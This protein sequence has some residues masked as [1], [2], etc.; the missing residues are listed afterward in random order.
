MAFRLVWFCWGLDCG[1]KTTN[2]GLCQPFPDALCGD[3]LDVCV[4]GRAHAYAPQKMAN[5][6]LY[7]A[8]GYDIDN[9]LSVTDFLSIKQKPHIGKYGTLLDGYDSGSY[10]IRTCDQWIK[11]NLVC[12]GNVPSCKDIKGVI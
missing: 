7:F 11:R 3:A 6:P 1:K 9:Q 5:Y 4:H 8:V 2:L 10:R 12:V